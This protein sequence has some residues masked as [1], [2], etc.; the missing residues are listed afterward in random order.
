VDRSVLSWICLRKLQI[1]RKRECRLLSRNSSQSFEKAR[2]TSWRR[3][4]IRYGRRSAHARCARRLAPEV[5]QRCP[6]P[7]SMMTMRSKLSGRP[8]RSATAARQYIASSS[9][10]NPETQAVAYDAGYPGGAVRS[11]QPFNRK[12]VPAIHAQIREIGRGYLPSA[13]YRSADDVGVT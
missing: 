11:L 6:S 3:N 8:R 9:R 12:P 1:N 7:T 13:F 2:A 5:L 10:G 4:R